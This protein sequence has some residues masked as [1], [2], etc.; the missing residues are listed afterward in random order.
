MAERTG[1]LTLGGLL[2]RVLP[3]GLSQSSSRSVDVHKTLYG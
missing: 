2:A 1:L 3:A